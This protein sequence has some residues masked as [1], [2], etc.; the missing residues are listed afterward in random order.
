MSDPVSK[1]E[2][3]SS[4]GRIDDTLHGLRNALE[5]LPVTQIDTVRQL[6]NQ[7]ASIQQTAIQSAI[8]R[9]LTNQNGAS[10]NANETQRHSERRHMNECGDEYASTSKR[11]MANSETTASAFVSIR[12]PEAFKAAQDV[13]AWLQRLDQYFTAA[14]IVD[15]VTQA[16]TLAN[17]LRNDVHA[18]L[19]KLKLGQ[20]TWNDPRALETI[21]ARQLDDNKTT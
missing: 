19:F 7:N 13:R 10:A 3:T 14:N 21:L 6:A 1:E 18:A 8:E 4:T 15:E 12:A 17:A 5:H 16:N 2:F 11:T 9:A 20:E